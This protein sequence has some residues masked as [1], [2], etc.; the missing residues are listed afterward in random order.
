MR[1]IKAGFGQDKQV[2]ATIFKEQNSNH[3]PI[4]L[5][6]IY[7]NRLDCEGVHVESIDSLHLLEKLENLNQ[8]YLEKGNTENGGF[9]YQRVAKIYDSVQLNGLKIPTIYLIKPDKIRYWTRSVALRDADE[10]AADMMMWRTTFDT[11]S[12]VMQG[13]SSG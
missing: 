3:L 5:V 11:E 4:R 12:E 10:L 9:F 1:V 13:S 7:L 6:A 8:L 2:C